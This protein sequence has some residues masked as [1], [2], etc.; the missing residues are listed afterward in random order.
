MDGWI[1]GCEEKLKVRYSSICNREG[2]KANRKGKWQTMERDRD[3]QNERQRQADRHKQT[4]RH[5]QRET[6]SQTDK[7][8]DREKE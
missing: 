4:D 8:A 3:R 7:Q 2:L 1:G 5:G 6:E